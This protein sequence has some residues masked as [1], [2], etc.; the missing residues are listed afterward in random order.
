MA[1]FKCLET[2]VIKINLN[3]SNCKLYIRSAYAVGN[4]KKE[5]MQELQTLFIELK[6]KDPLN[7]YILAGDL[8]ARH[9][10]WGNPSPNH[11]GLALNKWLDDNELEFKMKFNS[12][13]EPSMPREGSFLD[14]TIMDARLSVT[15]TVPDGRLKTIDYDSDHRGIQFNITT[16]NL[17]T[18]ET[19]TPQET[20][21]YGKTNWDD[22]A[23]FINKNSKLDIDEHINLSNEE[24]DKY[25]SEV[26]EIIT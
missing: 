17:L 26:Q 10:N 19:H 9:E 15:N 14:V 20:L 7:Y 24:I 12:S 25:I 2:T 11:R 3:I 1:N 16:E 18:L 13:H 21:N 22:F 4:N 23:K 6:R 8:N 5:F